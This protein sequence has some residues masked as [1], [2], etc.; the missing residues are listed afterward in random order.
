MT[1]ATMATTNR[2]TETAGAESELRAAARRRGLTMKDLAALMGVSAGYL[3]Q[4]A[5]GG[6]PWTPKMREKIA[7][8]L[9]EVPGQGT[10]YR[11]GGVVSSES[12]FIRERARTLGMTMKDLAD[13]A[14]VSYSYM[15][16]VARGRQHMGVKVQARVESALKAPAKVA[17]AQCANRQGCVVSGE[18]SYIRERARE[19]GMSL[20][21]LADRVGVSY[22]YMSMVAR[23]HSNM[24]V[25]VQAR[26]ES[27]LEAPAK[28][29][30][31]QPACIDREAM[32]DRMNAHGISQ[33]EAARRAGISSAHLS[34]VMNG[35]NSP[36][37]VVLRKLHGVLFQPTKAERVMPAEVKVLGWRKG[38]RSGMVVRGAGGPWAR[39]QVRR[40]DSSGRWPRALGREGGVRLPC[41]VRRHGPGIG[42]ARRRA[43]LLRH[44]E[45]AGDG[46]RVSIPLPRRTTSGAAAPAPLG[47]RR[48]ASEAAQ[49]ARFKP[50]SRGPPVVGLRTFNRNARGVAGTRTEPHRGNPGSG[51]VP[52]ATTERRTTRH[53]PRRLHRHLQGRHRPAGGG[54]LPAALPALGERRDAPQAAPHSP[55]GAGR[56]HQGRGPLPPKPTG[57]R[58]SSAR[59]ARVRPSSARRRRTWRASSGYSSSA[60][61][62]WC[63]SGSGRWSRRCPASGPPSS[64]PSPTWS[65][66]ASPSAPAPYSR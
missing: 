62:T 3:S 13:R 46:R 45:A 24:G 65:G 4:I 60:R 50:Q 17:P 5:N 51:V 57:A 33:N 9:G 12:S 28:V 20:R 14:G 61:L 59:W 26:V 16:Q 21:E 6:R 43:G 10:V 27:A 63:P 22:G 36:S 25:K 35:R 40:R 53:E 55:G 39:R 2:T 66:C 15:T 44:A 11:Q 52:P 47:S 30:P 8:V 37:A 31:A 32:W 58:R 34:Q 48:P 56:R 23:G 64:S 1:T 38:E 41:R 54:V 19:L 42:D 29:A 7:A 49:T 18:S